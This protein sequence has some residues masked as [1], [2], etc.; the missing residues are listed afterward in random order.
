MGHLFLGIAKG[1]ISRQM[2]KQKL[3]ISGV[4]R[5]LCRSLSAVECLAL[6]IEQLWCRQNLDAL[7]L[8][9]RRILIELALEQAGRRNDFN[10]YLT[11]RGVLGAR[12]DYEL[13]WLS[14][15]LSGI[16]RF[17][18]AHDEIYV[19]GGALRPEK[20]AGGSSYEGIRFGA[21]C[22]RNCLAGVQDV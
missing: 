16:H 17:V 19:F 4:S 11:V 20:L 3:D 6:G 5:L 13:T 18:F 21:H 10:N 8:L 15:E 9:R 2:L 22:S 12:V 7:D 14:Q 1:A